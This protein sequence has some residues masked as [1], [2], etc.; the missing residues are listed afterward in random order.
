[1]AM[2]PA[3]P[4]AFIDASAIVALVDRD[5]ETHQAAAEAYQTLV[6]EG[7]RLFTTNHAI[8]DAHELIVAGLG[9]QVAKEWLSKQNLAVYIAD[10]AD[11]ERAKQRILESPGNARLRYSDAVSYAVMQR[12]GVSEAFAVDPDFLR[13]LD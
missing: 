9:E 2:N 6:N 8:A 11:E 12:L 1:M 10:A 7:Y 13:H 3:H 5:D 4:A